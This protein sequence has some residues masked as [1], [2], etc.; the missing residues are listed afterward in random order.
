MTD[1]CKEL[2]HNELTKR[3]KSR[4]LVYKPIKLSKRFVRWLFNHYYCDEMLECF[5]DSEPHINDEVFKMYIDYT[6][7]DPDHTYSRFEHTE[8]ELRDAFVEAEH[9][10]REYEPQRLSFNN[11]VEVYGDGIWYMS[12]KTVDSCAREFLLSTKKCEASY[13]GRLFMAEHDGMISLYY[14]GRDTN[15]RADYHWTFQKRARRLR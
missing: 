9:A 8:D 14:F 1:Y 3:Y 5:Y 6:C 13:H 7:P 11:W 4:G 2:L 12:Q 10:Y 15:F